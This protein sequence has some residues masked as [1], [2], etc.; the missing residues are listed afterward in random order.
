MIA[1]RLSTIVDADEI[2][3]LM[4]GEAV[5]QGTHTSLLAKRGRMAKKEMG[6][7]SS[8]YFRHLRGYVVSSAE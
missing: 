4:N 3:V 5:E 7:T 2:I 1:H 6:K 8:D